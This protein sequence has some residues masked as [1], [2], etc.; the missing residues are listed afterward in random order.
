MNHNHQS[1]GFVVFVYV[2]TV[3]GR[4][5]GEFIGFAREVEAEATLGQT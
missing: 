4:R 1:F 5:E 2:E 3:V